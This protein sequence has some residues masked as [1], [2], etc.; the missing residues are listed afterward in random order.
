MDK[1][2]ITPKDFF[3]WAG[4]M[5][6]LYASVV[7][8]IALLFDYINYAFPDAL[9]YYSGDPYSSSISYEMASIIVLAPLFVILMRV[10]HRSIE[11]D[12]SRREVWVR[13]WALYLTL[14]VA[15]AAVAGDLIALV[16][17]FLNGDVTA[18]FLL[19]VLVIFLVA[20]ASFLHFLADM[21]DYWEREPKKAHLVGWA[22]GVLALCSIVSGFFIVGTPWQ[23]RLYRYDDQKVSDLQN[24]QYQIVNYW[25]LKE[26]LPPTL[27][28]L[29]DPLSNYIV[30]LD[31]QSGAEYAYTA[32]GPLSFRLCATFNAE[33]QLYSSTA[34]PARVVAVPGEKA[35]TPD[36]WQ[37]DAGEVCF[38]RTI[39]PEL[40]PPF[41]KTGVR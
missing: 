40:Y 18:R 34:T 4:A 13:R 10:I 21:R 1:P 41:S 6:A 35:Q 24:I 22:V 16:M 25:Q 17:Y 28:T 7:A 38:D 29:N 26:V 33:T 30:P 39:D 15:G 5:A 11:R 36:N 31:P 32:T 14:F 19:K 27:G 37:H 2:K 9:Q 20:G 12:A 8:F 3:L 23:A